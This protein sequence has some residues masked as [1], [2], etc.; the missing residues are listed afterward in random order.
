[1][2]ETLWQ[3]CEE[4]HCPILWVDEWCERESEKEVCLWLYSEQLVAK[5]K[6]Q[7][8]TSQIT[9]YPIDLNLKWSE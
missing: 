1:M 5:A 8:G 7:Q 4:S 9:V 3:P 2:L 6:I